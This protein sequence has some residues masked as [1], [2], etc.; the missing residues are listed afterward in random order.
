[1]STDRKQNIEDFP[2]INHARVFPGSEYLKSEEYLRGYMSL[3]HI[4]G[5]SPSENSSSSDT[6]KMSTASQSV[7]DIS[8]YAKQ[9]DVETSSSISMYPKKNHGR[10]YNVFTRVHDERQN[11]LYK[12]MYTLVQN[13]IFSNEN[14]S[15][16][17]S[18]LIDRIR[19]DKESMQCADLTKSIDDN[20]FKNLKECSSSDAAYIIV[21]QSGQ[22]LQTNQLLAFIIK[23]DIVLSHTVYDSASGFPKQN[24]V[25][26][27]AS[28]VPE[29]EEGYDVMYENSLQQKISDGLSEVQNEFHKVSTSSIAQSSDTSE[30]YKSA[31]I[32]KKFEEDSSAL[33]LKVQVK[34]LKLKK[35]IIQ[36]SELDS[37]AEKWS[38]KKYKNL[39]ENEIVEK[40]LKLVKQRDADRRALIVVE[41][42]RRNLARQIKSKLQGL[43]EHKEILNGMLLL[44][45][46]LLALKKIFST[47]LVATIKKRSGDNELHNLCNR[48]IVLEVSGRRVLNGLKLGDTSAILQNLAFKYKKTQL[49]VFFKLM[50]DSL[51]PIPQHVIQRDHEMAYRDTTQIIRRFEDTGCL[52]YFNIHFFQLV[53]ITSKLQYADAEIKKL[54]Y[55]ALEEGMVK[56]TETDI[57]EENP[58]YLM[59]LVA[60]IFRHHDAKKEF[61]FS[62]TSV[63]SSVAS[64]VFHD[65]RL[66]KKD[67]FGEEGKGQGWKRP[68]IESGGYTAHGEPIDFE[69]PIG[70][71]AAE[72][73]KQFENFA[74]ALKDKLRLSKE[75]EL[76]RV[77]INLDNNIDRFKSVVTRDMN[78]GIFFRSKLHDRKYYIYPYIAMSSA[79]QICAKCSDVTQSKGKFCDPKCFLA[80]C[81]NCQL[82]GHNRSLCHN[83]SKK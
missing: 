58:N 51:K 36:M 27:K 9:V 50:V 56:V 26:N 14:G 17:R 81:Q 37:S 29:G 11:E 12:K 83:I 63:N 79:D 76:Y 47:I 30:A 73:T 61:V 70:M 3:G 20:Y 35:T 42:E 18:A 8:S 31:A 44:L 60:K 54:L 43:K 39:Q 28:N 48:T 16:D 57:L 55:D 24:I 65:D 41:E 4:V 52:E 62:G 19:S 66:W 80:H 21:E 67:R 53:I 22:E 10:A 13:S 23:N 71:S 1:M 38:S 5:E 34:Y 33:T 69:V 75:R 74:M 15:F 78:V 72:I 77:V 2:E 7:S 32:D 59:D 82:F 6:L 46:G 68:V 40:Q 49:W 64:S 45:N 25:I